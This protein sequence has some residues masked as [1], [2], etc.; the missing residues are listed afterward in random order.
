MGQ[1]LVA[2]SEY[3]SFKNVYCTR[4][5]TTG[6]YIFFSTHFF[7]DQFCFEGYFTQKFCP[8]V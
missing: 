8:Y 5:I 1:I 4:V 3:L 6:G 2:F 7:E